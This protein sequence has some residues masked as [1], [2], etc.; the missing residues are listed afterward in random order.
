MA[1]EDFNNGL[2]IGLSLQGGM[3]IG[4][5]FNDIVI[6]AIE[7]NHTQLRVKYNDDTESTIFN[8]TYDSRADTYPFFCTTNCSTVFLSPVPP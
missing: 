8:S 7:S 6:K 2:I 5:G 4:N 1:A 3:F